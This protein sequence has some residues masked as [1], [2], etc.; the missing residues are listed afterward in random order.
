MGR[1]SVEV[2]YRE[3]GMMAWS[4]FVWLRIKT[5]SELCESVNRSSGYMKGRKHLDLL[6]YY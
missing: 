6:N 2:A 1:E 3:V 5:S 4:G